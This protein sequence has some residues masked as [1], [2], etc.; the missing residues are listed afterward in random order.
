MVDDKGKEVG[1]IGLWS[2]D[3]T[4]VDPVTG[5]PMDAA[6]VE[7]AARLLLGD[8]ID[9]AGGMSKVFLDRVL[10]DMSGVGQ[11]ALGGA[12]DERLADATGLGT[13]DD[14]SW[15]MRFEFDDGR[16]R[17]DAVPARTAPTRSAPAPQPS[18][19]EVLGRMYGDHMVPAPPEP[20]SIFD[21][22]VYGTGAP[23]GSVLV[24]SAGSAGVPAGSAGAL[25]GS[26]FVAPPPPGAASAPSRGVITAPRATGASGAGALYSPPA[27]PP[28]DPLRELW[29]P[30]PAGSLDELFEAVTP[31]RP[32]LPR[33]SP[34]APRGGGGDDP[35]DQGDLDRWAFDLGLLGALEAIPELLEATAKQ[36]ARN[37]L[38]LTPLGLPLAA[39]DISDLID[40]LGEAADRNGGGVPGLLDALNE[41]FN[42]LAG[43]VRNTVEAVEAAEDKDARKLGNRMFKLGF[44]VLGMAAMLR[45]GGKR[46]GEPGRTKPG[47]LPSLKQLK[48]D[49]SHIESGHIKGGHRLQQGAK[50]DVFPETMSEKQI[51]AAVRE[52][53]QNGTRIKTQSDPESTR[54]LVEGTGGGMTIRMWVNLTERIIET[55]WPQYKQRAR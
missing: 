28:R 55:A 35:N 37:A 11:A 16:S 26:P 49:M 43:L 12:P 44:E 34:G 5:E 21:A 9:G 14:P 2:G 13:S 20:P 24:P 1:T 17:T 50:K 46:S 47:N 52:A 51:E 3:G 39:E 45:G 29:P 15:S 7:R 53:Y 22:S 30:T 27:A 36:M 23:A 48:I 18:L 4:L 31:G 10:G 25:A 6:S 38:Y 33:G 8:T 19:L 32:Q 41:R 40:E 42:P 54:V